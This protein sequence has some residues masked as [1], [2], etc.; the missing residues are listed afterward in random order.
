MRFQCV[1]V[2]TGDIVLEER[3]RTPFLH[4][5]GN[6]V[7]GDIL[8]GLKTKMEIWYAVLCLAAQ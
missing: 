3:V 2:D 6:T 1:A 5:P 7:S 4:T 8:I